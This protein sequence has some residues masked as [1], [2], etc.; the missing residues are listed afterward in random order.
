TPLSQF[1]QTGVMTIAHL[2]LLPESYL[3]GLVDVKRMAQFY[4]T[5]ILGKV[6]PHGQWWYFPFVILVKTTLGM[7]ALVVLAAFAMF[8]GRLRKPRELAFLLIPC[9]V[10]LAVAILSGM[11]IGARHILP[12]YVLAAI[13][14]GAGVVALSSPEGAVTPSSAR[15]WAWI[16]AAL[17]AAHIASSIAAF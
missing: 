7:L 2:H 11:N 6:Y 16:G 3:M 14:A 13:L 5:F 15:R 17:I 4:P 12:V 1:E 10:Y 8:T 9:I